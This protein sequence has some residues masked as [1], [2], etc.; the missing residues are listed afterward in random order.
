MQYI[1]PKT[2]TIYS[3]DRAHWTH[4]PVTSESPSPYHVPVVEGGEH[5]GW[6]EDAD[7]KREAMDAMTAT[8]FQAKAALDDAG[9]LDQVEAY[10]QGDDVPRRVKLAW[11]EASFR[12]GS[13][14]V[15]DI[16]AELGLTEEQIDGL[17]LA[18]QEIDA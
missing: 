7:A 10:M 3:G 6:E 11:Q 15:A 9:L 16:G 14:M 2:N 13:K 4:I 1:N 18:A 8:R 5:T 17:F 12:R